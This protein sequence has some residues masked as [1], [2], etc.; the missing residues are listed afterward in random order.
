AATDEVRGR[1]QGV[2][3]VVV[4]GG[5]RL[6]DVTHG[7]AAAS[8]GTTAAAAGGG[9]LV[10]LLTGVAVLALPVFIRYRAPRAERGR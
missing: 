7:L 1:L 10:V 6:G 2:F 5:P 9:A 4:A 8:V 3:T